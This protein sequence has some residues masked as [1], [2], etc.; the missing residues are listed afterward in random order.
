MIILV[1]KLEQVI[2]GLGNAR[3]TDDGNCSHYSM[4][5]STDL[6]EANSNRSKLLGWRY[7]WRRTL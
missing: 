7:G 4:K 2:D 6:N 3:V 5:G 1:V